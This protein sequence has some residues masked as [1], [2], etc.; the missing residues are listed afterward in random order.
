MAD[1]R[2]EEQEGEPKVGLG[3]EEEF[4]HLFPLP[5][6]GFGTLRWVSYSIMPLTD[7]DAPDCWRV[8]AR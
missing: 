1:V 3:V 7:V 4:V 8:Y 2:A 5:D 6:F